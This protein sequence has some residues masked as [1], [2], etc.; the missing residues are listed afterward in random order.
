MNR[1]TAIAFAGTVLMLSGCGGGGGGGGFA[2][3]STPDTGRGSVVTSPP[4]QTAT[5]SAAQFTTVLNSTVQGQSLMQVAGTP[6]C[7]FE[8]RYLEYRTVGGQGEATNAT[9]AVMLPGGSDPDCTGPRPVVLYAHGTSSARNYNLAQ[10][11][12]QAQPAAGEGLLVAATFAA[13]GY[14]VVAPNYAG[15]DKSTLPYHPYLNGDQQGKDML[16]ALSV[17]SRARR[18]SRTIS[19]IANSGSFSMWC[20]IVS[21]VT[22]AHT[23]GSTACTLAERRP[24]SRDI[25]PT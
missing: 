10:W 7:A 3:T 17:A 2:L 9:A 20:S 11:T 1:L 16:R 14:I 24:P 12:D 22:M 15:Y 8:V 4:A 23:V 21:R 6:K 5:L 25:S 18:I 19:A 13:Q